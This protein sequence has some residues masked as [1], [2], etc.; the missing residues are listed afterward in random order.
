MTKNERFQVGKDEIRERLL[1]YTRGVFRI[2]PQIGKP[3]I[4][5][6]GCASGIQTPCG[7]LWIRDVNVGFAVR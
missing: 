6:I 4:L 1:K 7:S 3:R 2:V 5:D